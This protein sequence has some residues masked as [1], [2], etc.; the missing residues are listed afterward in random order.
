MKSIAVQAGNKLNL[1][2]KLLDVAFGDGKLADGRP[3]QRATV[4]VRVT[5]T[6]GGH[7]ETSDIQVGMFATEFTS[8][9]KCIFIL[10][11]KTHYV[12]LQIFHYI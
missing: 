4:T 2:G 3:Y 7:E 9:G 12:T 5:Q 8:T 10:C 6:Y 11:F 1:A